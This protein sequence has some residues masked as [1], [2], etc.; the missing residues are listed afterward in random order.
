MHYYIHIF[1]HNTEAVSASGLKLALSLR[2]HHMAADRFSSFL[3]SVLVRW[4]TKRAQAQPTL[5]LKTHLVDTPVGPVRVYDSG[6]GSQRP[7]VIFVPDGPNIVEHYETLISLLTPKLRVICFDMPGFGYSFPSAAYTHSLNQGAQAVLGVMDKLGVAQAAL[8][9][10]CANGFYAMRAAQKEPHRI[11]HLVLSQTPTLEDMHAWVDRIIPR[12]LKIPMLGQLM[13]WL[14]RK[15]VALRWYPTALPRSTDAT[16]YQEKTRYAMSCGSCFCL[17]GVVQGLVRSNPASLL[18]VATPCTV[19]WG[20]LDR[21]HKP[22][23][24][25]SLLACVPH[26]DIIEFDDCGHFPEIEQ[27]ARYADL[28]LRKLLG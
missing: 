18:G 14:F 27:P 19:V 5:T 22:T 17:A 1:I 12:P 28:L 25:D 11:T 2:S 4:Q 3:D 10:S 26:A 7:C 8:A 16:P 6:A 20:G 15:R 24:A 23:K 21:S 9:F 13:A